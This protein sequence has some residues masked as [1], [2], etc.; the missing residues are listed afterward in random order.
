MGQISIGEMACEV[1]SVIDIGIMEHRLNGTGWF[2]KLGKRLRSRD[3]EEI[4]LMRTGL[5][6]A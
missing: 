6:G 2:A 1:H 5:K 4:S 3:L